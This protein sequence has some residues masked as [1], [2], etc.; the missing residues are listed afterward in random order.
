VALRVNGGQ[1]TARSGA[2][3]SFRWRARPGRHRLVA[4][5]YDK[6]GNRG[7]SELRVRLRPA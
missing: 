6:R 1:V 3:L 2:R 7:A 4:V 5:A